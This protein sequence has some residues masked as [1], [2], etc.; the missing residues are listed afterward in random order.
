MHSLFLEL[1]IVV[2][3]AGVVA[4]I[5]FFLRQPLIIAY[6]VAGVL[7]GPF[8]FG[9]VTNLDTIH[10]IAKV[11]IM[12]L[13]FLVGL[14]MN[15]Q[16][17]RELGLVSVVAGVGQVIFT[18]IAGFVLALAFGFSI[19][20]AA[21]LAVALT[22][23]STV[24]ALK[25]LYDKNDTHALYGQI[26]IGILLV[27]DL[28]AILALLA[29]GGFTS[30]GFDVAHLGMLVGQGVLLAVVALV[31][32]RRLLNAL[33]GRVAASHELLILVSVSWAFIVTLASE[34]M[35]FSA[36][37]GA[38]IAGVSLAGLP[39][40]SEVV[41][42]AKVLRDFFI[43]IFFV[44]L[45]AGLVFASLG[46]YL[47]QFVGLS[48]LVIIGNPLIVLL[49]MVLL[50]YDS[51]TALFTGLAIANISEFS[52][53]VLAKGLELGHLTVIEV[54][55]GTLIGILTMTG[56]SYL[57]IYN[58]R[59][60]R[61]FKPFLK[62]L[63]RRRA[64]ASRGARPEE[65]TR[66]IL[67]GGGSTGSQVADLL[68]RHGTPFIVVDH[69]IH[70]IRD[71]MRRGM[72]CI[73]GDAE[74]E[75]VLREIGLANAELIISTVPAFEDNVAILRQLRAQ[76]VGKRPITILTADRGREGLE[77]FDLGADYVILRPFLGAS[78]ISHVHGELFGEV[79]DDARPI[80]VRGSGSGA[81][82]HDAD[83]AK[84]LHQ[85]NALRLVELKARL[86]ETPPA[87]AA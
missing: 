8:G 36:E 24:I 34:L 75:D 43:T 13:L 64:P 57:M 29:L 82:R 76:P 21:Y 62:K 70:V 77:L 5:G 42:K 25:I 12:L 86:H 51:R 28:L 33:F 9:L 52:L 60:Y 68:R 59:V 54:S 48:L 4:T 66:A 26:T 46:P 67:I 31:V 45:G 19:V 17:A 53:L 80:D 65:R 71:L 84:I 41:A 72:Q 6:L 73:F 79:A 85:L 14:E 11:G 7:V 35:G 38:F 44:A 63:D 81:P 78:H 3:A 74:D 10:V 58:Q 22:F 2:I 37:I 40:T 30:G 20:P 1:G 83:Y 27:Q 39:F 69:D 47:W 15:V 23:S 32:A 18:A 56:S 55:V 50:R 16:R 49:L 61:F 87:S